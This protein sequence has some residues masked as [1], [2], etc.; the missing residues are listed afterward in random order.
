MS[1]HVF[2]VK[3]INFV[4]FSDFSV[5]VWKCSESMVFWF[6]FHSYRGCRGGYHRFC[7]Y[8]IATGAVVVVIIGFVFIS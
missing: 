3:D 2:F 4:S 5:G 8:F 7:F 1:G 6:L